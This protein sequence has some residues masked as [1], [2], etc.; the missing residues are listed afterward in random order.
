M[1]K[2]NLNHLLQVNWADSSKI[3]WLYRFNISKWWDGD[4]LAAIRRFTF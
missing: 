2:T 3:D 1:E 4:H